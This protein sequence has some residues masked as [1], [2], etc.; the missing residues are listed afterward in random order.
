MKSNT[1]GEQNAI[2]LVVVVYSHICADSRCEKQFLAL[3]LFTI[4][5]S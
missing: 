3:L 5:Y 2:I 1:E 4:W